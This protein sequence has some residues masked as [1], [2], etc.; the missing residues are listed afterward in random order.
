[1]TILQDIHHMLPELFL[2]VMTMLLLMLGVFQ[3]KEDTNASGSISWI[4]LIVLIITFILL[5]SMNMPAG[6]VFDGLFIADGFATFLKMLI[7]FGAGVGVAYTSVDF[8][9]ANAWRFELPV[10]ILLATLGMMIM[11]SSGNFMTLYMGLELQSLALYILAAFKRDTEKSSEAGLKY[12][13]LGALSSGLLLYGISLIYGMTGTLQFAALSDILISGSSVGAMIGMVFVLA[14]LVFKVSAVPFHMWTPDVYEGSPTA[15]TAFF[16]IA[17]KVA[18]IGLLLRVLLN[19]MA[20]ML[21]EWQQIIIFVSVG[22]MILGAFA[23]I[24]QNNMKRLLAYSSIGHVGYALI[25]LAVGN[26]ASISALLFYISIYFVMSIG[27]FGVI[28]YLRNQNRSLETMDDLSGLAKDQPYV[29]FLMAV[30]M[31]SMAGIPPFAG[32]MAKLYVFKAA[33]DAGFY[34]LAV[35]GVL[36]SV[37]AAYYYLRVI[38]VM[39]FDEPVEETSVA[40]SSLMRAAISFSALVLIVLIFDTSMLSVHTESAAIS[41]MLSGQ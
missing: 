19:P 22:S 1:M 36:T 14:G 7:L 5:P 38:K 6:T 10:I 21:M 33:V 31:F 26:L 37:V 2:A 4:A 35:M 34:S 9:G 39:Y 24:V 27:A 41:L 30:F 16:A 11:V 32:F 17:P 13:V 40:N 12:F 8:R 29:A 25:G 3:E 18:A 28:I 15:I 20:G 23:G